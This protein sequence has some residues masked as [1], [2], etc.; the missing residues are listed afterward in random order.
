MGRGH[1][2][3]IAQALRQSKDYQS[4][5]PAHAQWLATVYDMAD[6]LATTNPSFRRETFLAACGVSDD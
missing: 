6:A 4:G 3:L 1:F 5:R 2:K